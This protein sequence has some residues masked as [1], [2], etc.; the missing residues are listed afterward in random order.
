MTQEQATK[1]AIEI[2]KQDGIEMVVTFN[3]YEEALYDWDKFGY[4]PSAAL[5]R[6]H[7][8]GA[9]QYDKA[10]SRINPQGEVKTTEE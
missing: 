5:G 9:F 10:I 6:M 7:A 4:F 3:P 1:E 2:A 8:K